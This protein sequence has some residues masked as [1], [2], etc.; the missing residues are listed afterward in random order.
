[1]GEA[2]GDFAWFGGDAR[3]PR[4]R[5]EAPRLPLLAFCADPLRHFAMSRLDPPEDG[6]VP[7]VDHAAVFLRP[8]VWRIVR[9]RGWTALS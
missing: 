9:L 6:V 5:I 3:Q 4:H 8:A 1:M 7:Y 2:Q